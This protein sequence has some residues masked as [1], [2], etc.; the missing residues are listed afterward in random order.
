LTAYLTASLLL[1]VCKMHTEFVNVPDALVSLYGARNCN[2]S[3]Q[4]FARNVRY[5]IRSKLLT[6]ATV[7][8]FF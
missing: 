2:A 3:Q 5:V 1:F 4:L 7:Y 6:A 8:K